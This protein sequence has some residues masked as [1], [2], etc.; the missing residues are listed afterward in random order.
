MSTTIVVIRERKNEEVERREGK[1]GGR[2]KG[3]EREK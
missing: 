2:K 1:K 3:R